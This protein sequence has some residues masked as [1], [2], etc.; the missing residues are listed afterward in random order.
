VDLR[1]LRASVE[2]QTIE[3][4]LDLRNALKLHLKFPQLVGER[5]LQ[6]ALLHCSFVR[7]SIL[8]LSVR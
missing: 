7:I 2:Q 5:R 4:R 1:L 6:P 3:L 8:E